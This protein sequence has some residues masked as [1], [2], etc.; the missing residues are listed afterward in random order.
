M[1]KLDLENIS[2][3]KEMMDELI[4]MLNNKEYTNEYIISKEEDLS[5]ENKINFYYIIFKYLIKDI[6]F[7]YQIPFL[8]KTMVFLKKLINK[9]QNKILLIKNFN[10]I[11]KKIKSIFVF[12]IGTDKNIEEEKIKSNLINILT[13]CINDNEH[14]YTKSNSSNFKTI[15]SKNE[16]ICELNCIIKIKD[17][18]SKDE[19][20]NEFIKEILEK[21]EYDFD[22]IIKSLNI[23]K[24]YE[25][26]FKEIITNK[27]FINTFKN[28]KILLFNKK[29]INEFFYFE[30]YINE[31]NELKNNL[32][33]NTNP[34]SIEIFRDWIKKEENNKSGLKNS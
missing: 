22:K 11:I 4:K 14:N 20:K 7:I 17:L 30:E 27:K 13:N 31:I 28:E 24:A 9:K 18:I 5:K 26:K 16:E 12:L 21:K 1:A 2:L 19:I 34:K 33:K 3:T 29:L 32:P 15:N 10:N 25:N 6:Y 23:N 8:F